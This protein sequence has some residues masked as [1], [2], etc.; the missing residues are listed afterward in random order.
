MLKRLQPKA[1]SPPSAKKRACT[2]STEP[3]TS[4]AAGGPSSAA[5]SSV[6]TRWPLEPVPGMAK[7]TICTANTKAPSTPMSGTRPSS[8]S[9]RTR[10]E[11]PAR[12]PPER[13]QKLPPTAAE[14]SASA[15]CMGPVYEEAGSGTG[16]WT[17]SP[18]GPRDGYPS[19]PN[20]QT[21]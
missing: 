12:A 6:P 2:S 20:Q 21:G 8:P 15:M 11:H 1:S 4:T 17:V 5:S 3:I 13:A 9:R 7:F 19:V 14:T 10:R 16:T 18:Q